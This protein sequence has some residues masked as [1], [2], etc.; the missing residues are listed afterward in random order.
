MTKY[1]LKDSLK[2]RRIPV[3]ILAAVFLFLTQ[4]QAFPFSTDKSA[5]SG[6][7]KKSPW[8][9]GKKEETLSVLQQ[10]GRFYRQEGLKLQNRGDL[11]AAMALYQK[12][13]ELDPA[14]AVTYNDLGIVYEA[15]GLLDEAEKCYLKSTRAD[16]Y[17]LSA[18]SNLAL[19]YENKRDLE[20]AAY[21]WQ[22]RTEMGLPG[23]P[24]TL[25]AKQRLKDIEMVL[26]SAPIG[27]SKQEDIFGFL[28]DVSKKKTILKKDDK[29]LAKN[30]FEKAQSS[31]RKGDEVT[32]LKIAIDANQLDPSNREIEKFISKVQTRLLSR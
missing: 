7:K 4:G 2:K 17:Y 21:Y 15:K 14:Y 1:I 22:K 24:W 27:E 3:I 23:D 16:P 8:P 31:F 28:K 13:I 10:Q 9:F 26:S 29:E 19:L 5:A 25:K 30:Y 20:K 11:D 6:P 32:A 18:Y 12:A